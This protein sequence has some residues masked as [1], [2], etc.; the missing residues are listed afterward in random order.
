MALYAV[1]GR[2]TISKVEWLDLQ[3][4]D[5]FFFYSLPGRKGES[6]VDDK[7]IAEIDQVRERGGG[8][9]VYKGEWVS[10]FCPLQRE[11]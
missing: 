11:D 5:F 6:K 10:W 8:R 4:Q 3:G 9:E 2:E 1:A 7:V